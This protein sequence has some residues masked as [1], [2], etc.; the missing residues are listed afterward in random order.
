MSLR[1]RVKDGFKVCPQCLENK[2]V[3]GGYYK[4]G[5]YQTCMSWCKACCKKNKPQSK[6]YWKAYYQKH[7]EERQA[8]DRLRHYDVSKTEFDFV[9]AAQ[10]KKCGICGVSRPRGKGGWHT[11]HCHVTGKF[12]GVLCGLCNMLLGCAKDDAGVLLKAADYLESQ[13]IVQVE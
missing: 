2:P 6:E 13:T 9:F 3:E 8:S 11:D 7:K 10:G 1:H 4:C 5:A 12:R